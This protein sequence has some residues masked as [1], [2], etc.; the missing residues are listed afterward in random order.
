VMVD[1]VMGDLTPVALLN[2]TFP[3]VEKTVKL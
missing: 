1:V 3:P 2:T